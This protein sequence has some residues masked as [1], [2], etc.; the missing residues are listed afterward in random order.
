MSSRG[1][2]GP[3]LHGPSRLIKSGVT[4]KSCCLFANKAVDLLLALVALMPL[5]ETDWKAS[6]NQWWC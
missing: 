6:E 5:T 1:G 4:M 2:G 3:L